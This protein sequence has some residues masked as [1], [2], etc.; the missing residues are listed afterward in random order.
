MTLH[1]SR[2]AEMA[3]DL[4]GRGVAVAEVSSTR[5]LRWANSALTTN[6]DT[7]DQSLALAAFVPVGDGTAS[8][9]AS[10]QVRS[11]DDVRALV[12]KAQA[13]ARAAGAA[14]DAADLVAGPVHSAF[15]DEPDTV[16]TAGLAVTAPA[17]RAAMSDPSLQY[18]G[19]AEESRD[20]MYV[21]TSAGTRLRYVDRVARFELCAK[22]PDRTR[23]AW[24]GQSGTS[25][26]D[27]HVDAHAATVRQ[28][29]EHQRTVMDID[30]GQHPVTLSP[31]AFADL[32]IY[33][34]W[35]SA[36]R[37]AHE[38]RSVFSNPL[39]GTRIGERLTPRSLSIATDRSEEHTS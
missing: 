20:T 39:G 31:S 12:A 8:G 17:L 19:Y 34:L 24:S 23:S 25:L 29:V 6:G 10:G 27:V 22:T 15:H 33:L 32:M 14:Q 36:A 9:V 3:V 4:M 1:M 13:S 18:F 38:G 21:A 5:N 28:G 30:P 26:A 7:V 37:E 16:D 2:A 35:M 11:E